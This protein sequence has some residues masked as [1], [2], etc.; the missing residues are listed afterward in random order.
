M[1]KTALTIVSAF[2]LTGAAF[3]QGTLN[4][5]AFI[6]TYITAQT[7]G[8]TYSSFTSA[9][10]GATGTGSVGATGTGTGTAGY[11]Y[12]LLYTASGATAPTTLSGLSTWTDTGFYAVDSTASA[13]RLAVGNGNSGIAPNGIA[14]GTTYSLILAG[15]SGNL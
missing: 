11:Y 13:G 1:K 15:W 9:G 3:A 2:A 14:V 10:V 5:S 8:T 6:P 4:F 7:N 12:E